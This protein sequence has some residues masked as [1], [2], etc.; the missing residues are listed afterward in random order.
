MRFFINGDTGDQIHG[1][2]VPD[3]PNEA[4]RVLVLAPDRPSVE[5]VATVY[6]LGMIDIAVHNTGLVAFI[7]DDAVF[8][9][10]ASEARLEIRDATTNI[11]IY[12]RHDGARHYTG[13]V[14][15]LDLSV[16]PQRRWL[17]GVTGGFTNVYRG[18]EGMTYE[19]LDSLVHIHHSPSLLLVGRPYLKRHFANLK[20]RD[21]LVL[22]LLRDPFE[23][24]AE[25]LLFMSMLARAQD[26]AALLQFATGLHA[27]V[28]FSRNL[29]LT[30]DRQLLEGFR[31]PTNEAKAALRDPLT[32]MLACEPDEA[33]KRI[34]VTQALDMLSSID[35]VGARDRFGEFRTICAGVVGMDMFDGF[36]PNA[37]PAV[38]ALADRLSRISVVQNLLEHDLAL[39]S[40]ATEAIDLGNATVSAASA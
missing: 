10:L 29:D 7:I 27:L 19:T 36:N 1:W 22:A 15:L 37:S 26:P 40:Y 21:F 11:V 5:V 8:P 34:H 3:N 13:R 6:N 24:M 23:D 16:L 12:R 2:V 28:D 17:N 14:A 32:R 9:G 30:N 35:V 39:Y 25:R 20:Q 4:S 18:V 38:R 33:A 31:R